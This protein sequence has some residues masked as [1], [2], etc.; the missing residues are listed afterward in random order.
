MILVTGG[1][2]LVGSHLLYHLALSYDGILATY[3]TEQKIEKVKK[4]FSYYEK[5][6]DVLFQKIQWIKADI[7][8]V[9][10]LE[11]VFS[12]PITKVYH[13]AALVS[14]SPKDYREM[15]KVNIKGTANVVNY[16]IDKEIR[17]LCYV[18][19]IATLGDSLNGKP[20]DEESEWND[21]TVN[22][23]YAITK[24]GAEM[25]VWRAS[26]EGVA[27]SVVNPGVI[28]GSGFWQEGTGK[29]FTQINKGFSFYTEGVTGFVGVKDVVN[30]MINLTNS[31]IVNQR[32]VLVSENKSF[33]EVLCLIAASMDKKPPSIKVRKF[34]TNILWRID[35]VISILTGKKPLLTKNS[36]RSSHNKTYYSSGKIIDELNFK[37]VPVDTVIAEVVSHYV[38]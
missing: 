4:V 29:L 12:Y 13:C 1:T 11:N 27:V 35:G 6:N 17:K 18:S 21:E 15:R 7:T 24:Y 23:G 33:K 22:S 16:C 8:E 34:I 38:S 2:G 19:S 32:Y 14:F 28:L 10:T 36:A 3:R 20:V 25:E 26:Q 5:N 30:A 37:F 9:P 31:D